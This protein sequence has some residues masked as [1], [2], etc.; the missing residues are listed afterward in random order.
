MV[1]W[2]ITDQWYD[3]KRQNADNEKKR[4]IE[5]AA[6]IMKNELKEFPQSNATGSTTYYPTIDDIKTDWIPDHI[7]LFLSSFIRF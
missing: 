1:D 4:I 7:R 6:K 5:T 2:T 3:N